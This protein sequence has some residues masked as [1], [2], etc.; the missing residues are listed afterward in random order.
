MKRTSRIPAP[1]IFLAV[2]FLAATAAPGKVRTRTIDYNDGDVD[3][4][5]YFAWDDSIEGKRPCV[6]VIHAWWGLGEDE[7]ARARQ[8]AEMG[9]AAFALDMYGTGRYTN[10]PA[11]AGRRAAPFYQDRQLA[12][13]R[14]AAGLIPLWAQ[15]EA[16][17]TRT[18][19]IGYCFGGTV[20]LELAWT[21][22]DLRGVVSFHGNPLP[23]L[24][25]DA[26][27]ARARLLICHGAADTLVPAETIGAFTQSLEGTKV[28]WQLITYGGAKHSF[29]TRS[30]DAVNIPG[31]GYHADADR[32]SWAHMRIFFEEI[33]AAPAA[34][35]S[36]RPTR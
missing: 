27:R 19:A 29:T 21:G 30:A 23:A 33:F 24:E 6:L 7:K 13:S 4:Q 14:A 32:R 20:A 11:E 25:G 17:H 5:G 28:D 10:D 15:P 26:D 31:V 3:L 36:P 9:Y 8:L 12:R 1:L 2:L 35:E 22:N 18:A 34:A 16:D